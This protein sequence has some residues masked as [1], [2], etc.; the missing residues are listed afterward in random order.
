MLV[1]L[2]KFLGR[3]A[4]INTG[5][6]VVG[7]LAMADITKLY[8]LSDRKCKSSKVNAA[9]AD[10]MISDRQIKLVTWRTRS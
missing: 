2:T 5:L 6:I 4:D 3:N 9:M 1:S 10:G 8:P 7:Q